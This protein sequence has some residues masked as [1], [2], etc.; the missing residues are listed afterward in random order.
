MFL[1]DKTRYRPTLARSAVSDGVSIAAVVVASHYRIENDRLVPLEE[2][3]APLP[4]SPPDVS[5][6]PLWK[7][8]SVTA[9]G[10][11]LCPLRAPFACPVSL[12]VG[13]E[14][15]RLTVFGER[16]WRKSPSGDLVATA[17]ER[18]EAIALSFQR[19][20]GGA[21]DLPPGLFPGTDL[22]FPGLRVM[23][24]QNPTGVG[25]YENAASATDQL[26]PNIEQADRLLQRWDDRPEPGG[27]TPCPDL[28]AL[29]FPT[30]PKAQEE[31]EKA[32]E[33]RERGVKMTGR[34]TG[35]IEGDLDLALR[36]FHY[37]P[38]RLIFPRVPMGTAI[39]LEGLGARA[40]HFTV[41]QSPVRAGTRR[42]GKNEEIRPALRSVHV[43]A[44][45]EIVSFVHDHAF[46][47]SPA[48]APE[49]VRVIERGQ[50]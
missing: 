2:P 13:A 18:F 10:A 31:I 4:T 43:D 16:R 41:P 19:A 23:Y 20:L 24:P 38:G 5:K 33:A 32:Q 44:D 22:P 6:L 34:I 25:F 45:G 26:L 37:A 49:W 46:H 15:R 3:P 17:P 35:S 40:L 12:R 14:E 47:Y 42:D 50:A 8:V 1:Q 21:Y 27:F 39:S 11:A 28:V 7:G 9:A 36:M 30:D 48:N 29:R